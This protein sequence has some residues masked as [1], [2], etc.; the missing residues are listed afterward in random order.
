MNEDSR[1]IVEPLTETEHKALKGFEEE[2]WHERY[3]GSADHFTTG[4][5][6]GSIVMAAEL[7]VAFF[8]GLLENFLK[9]F[10]GKPITGFLF[11]L[12][13][14]AIGGLVAWIAGSSSRARHKQLLSQVAQQSEVRS[15]IGK[16]KHVVEVAATITEF[17]EIIRYDQMNGPEFN[18]RVHKLVA[19]PS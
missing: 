15:G 12:A 19:D 16:L 9:W 6:I 7:L 17:R 11:L 2:L 13:P 1:I 3:S 5:I 4:A 18:E 8:A 10:D 14:I